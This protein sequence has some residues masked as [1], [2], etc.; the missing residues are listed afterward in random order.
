MK[1]DPQAWRAAFQEDGFVI[2]EEVLDAETLSALRDSLEKITRNPEGV[3]RDLQD[4][5]FFEHQHVKNNPQRVTDLTPEQCG[6]SVRQIADL[7]LFDA[8]FARL[9]CY[10]K[11]L[12]VLEALF[13]SDEFSFYLL[14]GRPK[15]A[16]VGNGIL[17]FHRDTP[18]EAFTNANTI[19]AIL[20]LDE[21]TKDNGPTVLI[22]GSHKVSDEEASDERWLNVPLEELNEE[23]KVEA[24]C[25][26]GSVLFFS[27]KI[28][29]ASFHNRSDKSRRT[30]ISGWAGADTLPTNELRYPYQG[31]KP[32]SKSA[33]H[34]KQLRMT[35]S[36]LAADQ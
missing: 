7:A 20:C 32:R 22:R 13:E 36:R 21:M 18:S 8:A 19:T 15:E 1:H 3:E 23:D 10:P 4:K 17:N 30:L 9:I 2:V 34:Q 6:N 26:A 29:H 28:I 25:P 5:L 31:L 12:D 14:V 24:C 33:L 16:R 27:S 35:F 11:L